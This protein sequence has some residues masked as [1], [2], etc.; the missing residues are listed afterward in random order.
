MQN[1]PFQPGNLVEI[2]RVGIGIPSGSLALI[3]ESH[4]GPGGASDE[5]I[6]TLQL[7]GNN[8]GISIRRYLERDLRR[9]S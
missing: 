8:K 3:I 1:K 9:V 5:K 4:P 7:V 2:L 6:H